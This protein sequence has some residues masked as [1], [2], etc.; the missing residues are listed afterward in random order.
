MNQP[1]RLAT[2][3]LLGFALDLVNIFIASVAYPDIGRSLG[4]SV[5]TWRGSA[6]PTCSA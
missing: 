1:S 6:T 5:A 2:L 4:A 3:Y